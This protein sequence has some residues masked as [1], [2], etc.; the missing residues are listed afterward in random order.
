MGSE[1]PLLCQ[2]AQTNACRMRWVSVALFVG[3]F[4]GMVWHDTRKWWLLRRPKAKRTGE[5]SQ[6]VASRYLRGRMPP[7]AAT[8]DN[9][10]AVNY[11]VVAMFVKKMS[12][13]R[14]SS[15]MYCDSELRSFTFG[16]PPPPPLYCTVWNKSKVLPLLHDVFSVL[17]PLGE[18]EVDPAKKAS[19]NTPNPSPRWFDTSPAPGNWCHRVCGFTFFAL[20]F[21]NMALW[22]VSGGGFLLS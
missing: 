6:C 9:M 14:S 20:I 11:V 4:V 21:I 15:C 1:T 12:T 8:S 16:R 18:A 22:V 17:Y 2:H 5:G 10:H 13:S 7:S 19:L 3:L